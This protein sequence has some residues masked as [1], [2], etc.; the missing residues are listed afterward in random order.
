MMHMAWR[1]VAAGAITASMIVPKAG[2][3]D[4]QAVANGKNDRCPASPPGRHSHIPAN[5]LLL[6]VL[7]LP[8]S[9]NN[10]IPGTLR[11]QPR[12]SR[13]TDHAS[14][15]P[16]AGYISGQPPLAAY[17]P[18]PAWPAAFRIPAPQ[19]PRKLRCPIPR[20]EFCFRTRRPGTEKIRS[21]ESKSAVARGLRGIGVYLWRVPLIVP[22]RQIACT[23]GATLP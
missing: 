14:M 2:K 13:H 11:V 4:G 16:G 8:L 10:G 7:E 21:S 5:A 12:T 6:S 19:A 23:T 20:V 17:R 15:V 3:G 1:R 18:V 22:A 9:G